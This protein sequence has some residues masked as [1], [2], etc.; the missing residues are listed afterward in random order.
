MSEHADSRAPRAALPGGWLL[1]AALLTV[2]ASAQTGTN[3]T[4]GSNAPNA[5]ASTNFDG[6]IVAFASEATNLVSGTTQ[7]NVYHRNLTT[8]V[9]TRVAR[10]PGGVQPDARSDSPAISADGR[11]V[12]YRSEATNISPLAPSGQSNIY[13]YDVQ[14][15]TT[16]LI[17]TSAFGGGEPNGPSTSPAISSDGRFV[18]FYSSAS[19]VVLAGGIYTHAYV[20][21]TATFTSYRASESSTGVEGNWHSSP[22]YYL[23]SADIA[24]EGIGSEEELIAL[25]VTFHSD[26][27]NLVPGDANGVRDVF[28]KEVVSGAQ[29]RMTTVVSGREPVSDSYAPDISQLVS[30]LGGPYVA[31]LSRSNNLVAGD[32]NG[33]AEDVFRWDVLAGTVVRVNLNTLGAQGTL[34]PTTIPPTIYPLA[35]APS[36][37]FDGNFVAYDSI[38]L[39][40]HYYDTNDV[41]DV[42]KRDVALGK[43]YRLSEPQTAGNG[44]DHSWGN[45]ISGDGQLAAFQSWATNLVLSDTN[46]H[47]DIFVTTLD[48]FYAAFCFGDGSGTACPCGNT[49]DLRRG[50]EN[51]AATGGAYLMASGTASLSADDLNLIVRELPASVTTYFVQG[52]SLYGAPTIM[53]D[54]IR[55]HGGP[56]I[57]TKTANASG[58]VTCGPAAGDSPIS[59]MSTI[60]AGS[61]RYYQAG[62]VASPTLCS[63]AAFNWSNAVSVVWMP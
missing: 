61:T 39:G 11:Y 9:L 18:A 8:S 51:A 14:T 19:D 46:G 56:T 26:A 41:T 30:P 33:S 50:C 2:P 13:R 55:C 47:A 45:S 6:S 32:T 4:R 53:G 22:R 37:S 21:D 15:G 10:G 34:P 42:M 58:I 49:G 38:L 57:A 1:A 59:T 48:Q 20:Y 63:G 5:Q 23:G 12:A 16:M 35:F 27:D 54:G 60:L 31:F 62:Y 7:P 52:S 43:T 25:W 17:S 24:V 29:Y 44:N 40:L 36:I 28:A 3:L